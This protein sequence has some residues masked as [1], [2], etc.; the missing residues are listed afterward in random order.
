MKK[1]LMIGAGLVVLDQA[2]KFVV[3]ANMSAGQSIPVI[4]N[5]FHLTFVKNTGGVWGFFK[6]QSMFLVWLSIMAIGALLYFWD[7]FELPEIMQS[8]ILAGVVGNLIDRIFLGYVI[9]FFDFRIWPVFNFADSFI[10]LSIIYILYLEI[11]NY[12]AQS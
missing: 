4:A 8:V 10:T 12:S 9:D 5:I 7:Q 3:R 6:G 1:P 2:T 11:K